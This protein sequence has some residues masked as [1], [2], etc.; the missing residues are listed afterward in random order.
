MGEQPWY[1]PFFT[2]GNWQCSS[3]ICGKQNAVSG[4]WTV[5]CK[6]TGHLERLPA[7]A[8]LTHTLPFTPISHWLWGS[9]KNLCMFCIWSWQ[10]GSHHSHFTLPHSHIPTVYSI[11]TVYTNSLLL[12]YSWL[13]FWHFIIHTANYD[14][15]LCL[16]CI[17]II[18]IM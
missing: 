13:S 4:A 9:Y 11:T 14:F 10:F 1:C 15:L 12:F 8:Q 16:Y 7:T 17:L 6:R 3:E 18:F 5:P 2:M